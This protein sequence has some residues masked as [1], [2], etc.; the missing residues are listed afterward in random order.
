MHLGGCDGEHDFELIRVHL[1]PDE[2]REDG[3]DES[4]VDE[5]QTV[6]HLCATR[7]R[8]SLANCE[9]LLILEDVSRVEAASLHEIGT[10]H[11][12]IYPSQLVDIFIVELDFIHQKS[13][14]EIES[15]KF[16]SK[17]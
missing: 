13:I 12:F 1:R 4:I 11:L 3:G 5:V 6:Q 17:Y 2:Q 16:G 14:I 8:E 7:S 10:H 15:M 9:E